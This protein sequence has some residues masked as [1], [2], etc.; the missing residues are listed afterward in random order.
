MTWPVK[1]TKDFEADTG[2]L[3]I[4]ERI[5]EGYAQPRKYCVG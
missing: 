4:S 5:T 2:F 3:T 1:K